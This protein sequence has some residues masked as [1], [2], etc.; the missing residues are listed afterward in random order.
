VNSPDVVQLV[1][2]RHWQHKLDRS[3]FLSIEPLQPKRT[4]IGWPG[5]NPEHGVR[6]NLMDLYGRMP[7]LLFAY[8]PL[9]HPGF[10]DLWETLNTI[11]ILQYNEVKEARFKAEIRESRPDC[12]I[13]HHVNDFHAQAARLRTWGVRVVRH[14]PHVADP[15]IFRNLALPKEW[16]V[17]TVGAQSGKIYPLRRQCRQACVLLRERGFRCLDFAHPGNELTDATTLDHLRHFAKVCNQAR[18]VTFC[19]SIYKYRLQKYVEVPACGAAVAADFPEGASPPMIVCRADESIEETANLL[20]TCLKDN[21]DATLALEGMKWAGDY[22]PAF[23][24][25]EVLHMVS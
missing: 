15:A 23:Y 9:E 10:A 12:V 3:R 5:Y 24:V 21:V 4:G 2:H 20:E 14:I 16:D 8:K 13:F 7:D 17:V 1:S 19:A 18:I 25:D 22:T 6:R 11:T